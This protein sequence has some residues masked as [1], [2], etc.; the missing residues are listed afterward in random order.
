MARLTQVDYDR[1]MA[2][3]ATT[4]KEDGSG[5][6]TFGTIRTFT[7]LH[8]EKAEYAILVRSDIKRQQLGRKLMEKMVRYCR[9]RGT[10][11]I[12]GQVLCNNRSML[13]LIGS[14]GFKSKKV[15]DENI[16]EVVLD[17]QPA[18]RQPDA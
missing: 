4:P 10:H 18:L 6:E 5:W 3:I 7:D 13:D 12:V 2:F 8:N 9:S 16:M 17:L 1:E 11:Q 15:L 14:L